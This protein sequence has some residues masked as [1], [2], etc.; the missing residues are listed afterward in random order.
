MNLKLLELG[1]HAVSLTLPVTF[2][3]TLSLILHIAL[4]AFNV[5]GYCCSN[6][7]KILSYRLNGLFMLIVSIGIF[8]YLETNLQLIFHRYFIENMLIAN[9]Y[10]FVS[11]IIF[12]ARGGK[13]DF[14]RCLTID[15]VKEGTLPP[16]A[17]DFSSFSS[18]S[19]L[20]TFFLGCEWNP[21]ICGVDV[22]MFLYAVGAI[23]LQINVLSFTAYQMS[24]WGG[25]LSLAMGLYT[26]LFTWFLAEYMA[27]EFIHL[28]TFDLFAEKI[29]F[30]LL[31][32]CLTFYPFFYPLGGY[33]LSNI[34]RGVDLTPV[35]A[36]LIALLF[37]LGW[38]IT[39]GAN[40]QKFYFRRYPTYKTFFFGLISQKTVPGSRILCSGWW[41]MA[42]HFNYFGEILQ[43]CALSFPLFLLSHDVGGKVIAIM[44]PFYYCLLFIP[45]QRDDD[46]LCRGKYGKLW[47]E[48][49]AR[50][51]WRIV[52]YVY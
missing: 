5:E 49:E 4:P 20:L 47:D 18:S 24:N 25:E 8:Y 9:V 36:T 14:K 28:Y 7:G 44:Y 2:V 41:G 27:L 43:A 16:P 3:Y 1:A 23:Q 17:K 45:R 10:G 51:P 50:V 35:S 46:E 21:R 32:G 42:R 52:P 15:Q 31:W 11:S 33:Y 34:P 38:V 37:F 48:Y 26:L 22:K 12:Y 19:S 40:L 29:G 13:E 30:K 6:D 39:R